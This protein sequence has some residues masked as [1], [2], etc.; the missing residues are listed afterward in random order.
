[1]RTD[2]INYVDLMNEIGK[3]NGF[4]NAADYWKSSFEDPKFEE[5][6]DALWTKVKPL[7]N[8]LHS[9]MRYKLMDIYGK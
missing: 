5:K 9:Y 1:M 6:V 7:Y 8:A 2:Y 3:G 4:E